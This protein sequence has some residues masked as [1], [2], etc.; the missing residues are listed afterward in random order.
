MYRPSTLELSYTQVVV[1]VP[2]VW[3]KTL[4]QPLITAKRKLI[5][6]GKVERALFWLSRE[7]KP[8]TV[9]KPCAHYTHEL[10]CDASKWWYLTKE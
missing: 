3:E 6:S 7:P 8:A 9:I 5:S 10:N 2:A 4:R 1:A